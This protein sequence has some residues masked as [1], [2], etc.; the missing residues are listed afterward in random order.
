MLS[1]KMRRMTEPKAV[2]QHFLSELDN[3]MD[4]AGIKNELIH[5]AAKSGKIVGVQES[6][7][8]IDLQQVERMGDVYDDVLDM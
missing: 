6:A 1:I 4:M 3:Y 8:E 5:A 7:Y 2:W